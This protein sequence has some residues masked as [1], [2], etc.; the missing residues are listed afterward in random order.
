[1]I[2][3]QNSDGGKKAAPQ[4][5][6]FFTRTDLK[7]GTQQVR[8]KPNASLAKVFVVD[9]FVSGRIGTNND[10]GQIGSWPSSARLW[11]WNPV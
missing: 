3:T 8:N 1:M 7:P 2:G 10:A 11:T 6:K 9:S 4:N 5:S